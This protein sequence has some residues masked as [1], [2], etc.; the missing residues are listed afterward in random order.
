MA[1]VDVRNSRISGR[2]GFLGRRGDRHFPKQI[3]DGR[4][5]PGQRQ[6]RAERAGARDNVTSLHSAALQRDVHIT[7]AAESKARAESETTIRRCR[8]ERAERRLPRAVCDDSLLGVAGA[9][10]TRVFL[11]LTVSGVI[12]GV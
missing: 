8:S 1:C 11:A 12:R 3:S 7:T 6:T 9:E 10:L 4:K 2:E 5:T